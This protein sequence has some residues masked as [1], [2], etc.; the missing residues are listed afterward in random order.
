MVD[1]VNDLDNA[2]DDAIYDMWLLAE[3]YIKEHDLKEITARQ[4]RDRIEYDSHD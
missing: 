2:P 3:Q 1:T 4:E